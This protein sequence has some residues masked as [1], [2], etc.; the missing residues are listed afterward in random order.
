[1][2][3]QRAFAAAGGAAEHQELPLFDREAHLLQ[4]GPRLLRIG[5]GQASD[6]KCFHF[7]SSIPFKMTGVRH[8]AR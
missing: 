7:L 1:M 6:F 2:P 4:R 5:E 8:K 3:E